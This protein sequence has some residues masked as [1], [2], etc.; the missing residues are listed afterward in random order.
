M[1][2]AYYI[3]FGSADR[4]YDK[5]FHRGF[6]KVVLIKKIGDKEKFIVLNPDHTLSIE[7]QDNIKTTFHDLK[8]ILKY[9]IVKIEIDKAW[10]PKSK[11]NFFP[12][13]WG[14]T[15]DICIIKYILGIRHWCFTPYGLFRFLLLPKFSH[16]NRH[17][18]NRVLI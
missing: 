12:Q 5:F 11:F 14:I 13:R 9:K 2:E 8:N 16:K 1:L 15:M 17:L 18:I 3:L 4:W 6:S 10:L 7:M